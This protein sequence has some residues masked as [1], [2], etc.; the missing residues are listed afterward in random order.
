MLL[1]MSSRNKDTAMLQMSS[2]NKDTAMLQMSSYKTA[3]CANTGTFKNDLARFLPPPF[4]SKPPVRLIAPCFGFLDRWKALDRLFDLC[5][6][7]LTS[8]DK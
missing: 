4:F 6:A 5:R 7:S 2:R 1:Q 8:P 3:V